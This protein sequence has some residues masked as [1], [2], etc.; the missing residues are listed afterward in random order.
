M[1]DYVS[2]A[3]S[4]LVVDDDE[5]I[6][7]T[8]AD[9]LRD[10]GYTVRVAADGSEALVEM[11][12]CAPCVVLLDLMMPRIDGWQVVE[13]MRRDPELAEIPVCIVSL[14]AIARRQSRRA[15]VT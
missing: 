9:V 4:V 7:E 6:R 8:V 13:E 14:T 12:D 11:R 3:R 15:T 2:G 5:D 10:A 1:A